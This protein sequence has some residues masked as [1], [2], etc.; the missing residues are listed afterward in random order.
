[1]NTYLNIRNP[2]EYS[3]LEELVADMDN[4]NG[5]SKEV[6]DDIQGVLDK[7]HIVINRIKLESNTHFAV[8]S[9]EYKGIP[10]DKRLLTAY[11]KKNSV[12]DNTMNTA[13][14]LRGNGNDTATPENAVS[15][16]KNNA[17]E[18]KNQEKVQKNFSK[19]TIER[20]SQPPVVMNLFQKP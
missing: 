19:P 13:E 20:L 15:Q 16:D 10:R 7:M 9:K 14:T 3:S 11:E 12:L 18:T 2:K 8:I 5:N 6:L 4:G 1:M 17:T